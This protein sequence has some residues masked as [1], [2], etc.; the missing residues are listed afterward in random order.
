[1]QKR[2]GAFFII[3]LLISVAVI[4]L[5]AALS[6]KQDVAQVERVK[7]TEVITQQKT[8]ELGDAMQGVKDG[9]EAGYEDL[10]TKISE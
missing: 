4:I 9:I 6:A 1:M 10:D 8:E 2:T 7:E 3:F 5:V